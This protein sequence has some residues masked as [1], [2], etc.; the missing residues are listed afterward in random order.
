MIYSVKLRYIG[1]I[2]NSNCSLQYECNVWLIIVWGCITTKLTKIINLVFFFKWI[3]LIQ[4]GIFGLNCSWLL[5]VTILI[6]RIKCNN[7]RTIILGSCSHCLS[8]VVFF[9]FFII[10]GKRRAM[11]D[12]RWR[13]VCHRYYYASS[14][15]S[16]WETTT[17]SN[18]H[19]H[20]KIIQ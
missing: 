16:G 7:R 1:W 15:S 3:Y 6:N 13:E 8:S 11:L 9:F 14:S 4:K 12:P 2:L 20:R 17:D 5:F 10:S 19:A 18:I